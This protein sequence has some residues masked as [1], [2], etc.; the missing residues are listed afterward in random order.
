MQSKRL[1][2]ISS[3]KKNTYCKHCDTELYRYDVKILVFHDHQ[4]KGLIVNKYEFCTRWHHIPQIFTSSYEF[5]EKK[6]LNWIL[7]LYI[8]LVFTCANFVINLNLQLFLLAV[9]HS[10]LSQLI[11]TCC[12]NLTSVLGFN[13][14]VNYWKQLTF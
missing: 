4:H 12:A 11:N 14:Q 1:P 7:L 9:C 13:P 10:Y 2:L 3:T 6:Y 5:K 8:Y